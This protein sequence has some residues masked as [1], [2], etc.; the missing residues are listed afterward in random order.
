MHKINCANL[1]KLLDKTGFA[2]YNVSTGLGNGSQPEEW[3][4]TMSEV[5]N[6]KAKRPSKKVLMAE[7]QNMGVD[8]KIVQSLARA[9]V[10]TMLFVKDLIAKGQ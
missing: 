5:K 9:N 3:R 10:D 1:K 2:P 6:V 4:K 7:I 8:T